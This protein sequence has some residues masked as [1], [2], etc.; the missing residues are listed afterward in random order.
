MPSMGNDGSSRRLWRGGAFGR[1]SVLVMLTV[2]GAMAVL[3]AAAAL[4]AT[5][6]PA[7][8][9]VLAPT[10]AVVGGAIALMLLIDAV[11]AA[12]IVLTVSTSSVHVHP[13]VL[14]PAGT[15]LPL[16]SIRSAHATHTPG[17][18]WRSWGWWWLARP[19]QTVA[20]RTGPAL[21]LRLADGRHIVISVDRTEE[22][23][24]AVQA[25]LTDRR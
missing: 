19:A 15:R 24:R 23:A 14:P 21:D 12:R 11:A 4:A 2:G 10:A 22:C 18:P 1:A 16:S 17:R 7:P 6:L 9:Q 8:W 20:V 13:A 25:L 3:A 5:R